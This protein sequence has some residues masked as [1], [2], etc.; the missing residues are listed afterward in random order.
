[1]K[2]DDLDARMRIYETEHDRCVPPDVFMVA[3]LDGRG[4]S[5][6]RKI[7]S[8]RAAS[9]PFRFRDALFCLPNALFNAERLPSRLGTHRVLRQIHWKSRQTHWVLR[10]I[11]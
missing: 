8:W 1:M 6:Y 7:T 5:V 2:F 10:Q 4:G 3:R 9:G 11:H